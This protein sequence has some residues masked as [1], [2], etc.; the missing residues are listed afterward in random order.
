M[1]YKHVFN[2]VMDVW[3][4]AHARCSKAGA[5]HLESRCHGAGNR[6][7]GVSMSVLSLSWFRASS[8][9]FFL[10]PQCCPSHRAVLEGE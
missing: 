3:F 1:I 4:L 5:H 7:G 2:A 9:P 6:V 10:A 8:H